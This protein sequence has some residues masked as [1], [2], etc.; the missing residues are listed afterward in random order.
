MFTLP[1]VFTVP[2]TVVVPDAVITRRAA[3]IRAAIAALGH[4]QKTAADV[5]RCAESQL[6]RLIASGSVDARFDLLTPDFVALV[7]TI[8]AASR[9]VAPAQ[10]DRKFA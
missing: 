7:G 1:F 5:M 3:A 8:L 4:S 2:H 10:S 6:S 9:G